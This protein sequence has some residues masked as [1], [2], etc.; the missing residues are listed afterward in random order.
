MSSSLLLQGHVNQEET[1]KNGR[2]RVLLTSVVP[3]RNDGGC[4]I[5]MHRHMVQRTPFEL[6]VASS[7]DFADDLL[8]DTHL[9]LPTAMERLR[10]TRF[11][12]AV[13]S[14]ITDY[15]NFVWPYRKN[16]DLEAAIE[17]FQPDVLLTLAETSVSQLALKAAARHSLPLVGLFWDWF[18]VMKPH[19]G[20][21]WTRK[22]LSKR[23]RKLYSA[24]DLAFCISAGMQEAL[25]PHPNSH[26]VHPIAGQHRISASS[27][28]LSKFRVAYVGS[29]RNFYGRMLS[30]LIERMDDEPNLEIT[31]VGGDADWPA[32]IVEKARAK[33]VYLGFLP[34][35]KAAGVLAEADALLVVMSFEKE[36]ELF[37]RTSFTTKFADYLTFHKPIILWA[38]EYC[39]PMQLVRR[40]GGALPVAD[41]S[42]EAVLVAIRSLAA[43]ARQRAHWG[44]EA[45]RLNTTT[46]HPDRL[47]TT[48]VSQIDSLVGNN[49]K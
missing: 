44:E 36:H 14:W 1:L 48:F 33:G 46:F 21:D 34:P 29:V 4:R 24:C 43:D 49:R 41:A 39:A 3:P 20:H 27:E 11:G 22:A 5:L 6:H 18:P 32:H 9:Q 26:V 45:R 13:A 16:R 19:Y 12:P 35:E 38:P 8:I 25:G 7:A 37:M 30:A 40:E 42:T 15:E 47:Q 23:Y 17:K 2:T 28:K 31:I 10:K